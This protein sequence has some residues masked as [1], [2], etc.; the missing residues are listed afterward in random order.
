M[1]Y[2]PEDRMIDGC[3]SDASNE[4]NLIS[5]IY[6]DPSLSGKFFLKGKNIKKRS[7]DLIQ[8]FSVKTNSEKEKIGSLSGGNIQ[9]VVVAREW[10]TDPN[11]MIAEQPTRGIDVGSANYIHK[12]LI[13]MRNNGKAILLV[14]ADLNEVLSL[15]DRLI[16]MEDGKIVA[17]FDSLK[18]VTESQL[19]LYMLGVK[20]QSEEEIRGACY[21]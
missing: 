8:R 3:A 16:V 1:S 9:K 20:H 2:I 10:S 6:K 11:I 18:E 14:S 12:E 5:T 17:Y 15:S 19:G 4:E 21:D 13:E 7:L